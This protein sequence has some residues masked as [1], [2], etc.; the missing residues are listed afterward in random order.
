MQRIQDAFISYG[1]A[2]SRQFAKRLRDCL[3]ES[4]L[5]VWF[6]FDDIPIGVDYQNQ[7][8]DGI[9]RSN[10]F[11]FIISPHSVNSAY[12]T[13]EIELALKYHKRIIPLLHVEEISFD[14]WQ[15]RHP[16]KT[17]DDWDSEQEQSR[18]SSF[19]NLH[20]E[21]GKINWVYF[22]DGV[23]SFEVGLRGL[24]ATIERQQSY[25]YQ[26]T[27]L[28]IQALAWQRQQRQ[29]AYLLTQAPLVEANAWLQQRFQ[30]EQPPCLPTDLHCEFITESIKAADGEMTQIFL[31]YSEDDRTIQE[32]IRRRLMREGLTVWVNTQDI[33]TAEDFQSAINRGI[34]KANTLVFLL[35]P[36]SIA[37]EYCQQELSYAR[38]Y[39]K[40]IIPLLVQPLDL[41][42]LP[43]DLRT[44]QF[45]DFSAL[46]SDPHFDRAINELLR[47]LQTAAD[48]TDRHKRLLVRALAWERQGRDRKFLLRG[49]AFTEAQAWLTQPV[50]ES[51]TPTDLHMA[52]I[53]ASRDIHQFYDAFISYGR[54]DSKAFATQLYQHLSDRGFQVWFDQN[55]IPLAVDF[56]Q[57]IN[58]GIEKSHNF[59]FVI[60]PHSVNSTYCLK[61][62][63]WAVRHN[64]RIVP[65]LHVEEV[66]YETWQQ[67]HPN[68]SV[69]EWQAYQAA[70]KQHIF[71]NMPPA[72]GKINWLNAREGIDEY[73]A[74]LT[75]L[76]GLFH[77]HDNY[78][79]QHTE[80]LIKALAWARHQ[81]Q[82]N[83][84]LTG[85]ERL[86]GQ[87]WL[88]T[89]FR[90]EQPPCH[91][92]P[93]HAEL[94]TES[95]KAANGGMTQVFLSYAEENRAV[96]ETIQ[97]RLIQA[98][99]TVWADTGDIQT[100][101]DFEVALQRG[102]EEADNV[103]YLISK[104]ALNSTYC[105][106]EIKQALSLNKRVIPMLVEPM[107]LGQLSDTLRRIQFVNL[108]D[109]NT[110][111][112]LDKDLTELL[113]TLRQNAAYYSQ[114]KRLLVSAL[115]WQRQKQ[116]TSL[117]LQ[118]QS[119]EKA[120]SWAQTA[121]QHPQHPILPIQRQFL[122]VS[123]QQPPE[124]TL[125]VFICHHVNDFDFSAQLQSTLVVQG[126]STWFTPEGAE[127]DAETP[128]ATHQAIDNAE[129]F[130]FVLSPSSARS[131]ACLDQLA[132]ARARQKRIVP[133][134]YRDVLQSSMP[135]EIESLPRSDFRRHDGDFLL[136]FGE[137]F[138][139][140]ESDPAHVRSHTRLLVKAT[141]W[142]IHDRDDSYLLRG[143]D[144]SISE[145]WLQQAVGKIPQPTDLQQA[146]LRASQL[147]P[148]KKIRGRSVA[149]TAI[150]TTGIIAALRLLGGLQPLELLA[151]DQFL[152]LRPSESAQ[153]ER[154]LIVKVD[155]QSGEWLREQ[156]ITEHYE[157][158]I[159]TIP[160][161]A[162]DQAIQYLIEQDPQLIGLD[163]YRDFPA[164][165]GL[166]QTLAQTDRLLGIC[167]SASELESDI[168]N[169][170][171]PPFRVGF[172]NLLVDGS[173]TVRRHYLN[174]WIDDETDCA[175]QES[176]SLL[177]AKTYL[178]HQD[179]DYQDPYAEEI[180][181]P[182]QLGAVTVPEITGNGT[183]YGGNTRLWGWS[184][185]QGY[186]T[187]LNYRIVDGQLENF[188]DAVSLSEVVQGT[189]SPDLIRDRVVLI[190]YT[191]F[192]DRN[193]DD[194]NTPY[195]D[196]VPGV[197]L[198]GQMTSQLISAVVE[199]RPLIRWW[200]LWIETG[201]L[202]CWA[203]IGGL[204]F[205]QFVR[206]RPLA[207]ASV[208][209]VAG[210]TLGCYGLLIG[211]VL[212]VPWV[213]ALLSWGVTGGSIGYLT[214]RHRKS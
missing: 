132:Y 70:G 26:H 100:G 8:D 170:G 21:I 182:L 101:E 99:L 193:S 115:K 28:L 176:F 68:G 194:F 211:P 150:V 43:A 156:M 32:R 168:P 31:S 107:D 74:A 149:V 22:R 112:D 165:P 34:E 208:A 159:G 10:N 124:Q 66:S 145:Q 191:D 125:G 72:I 128:E 131:Q 62:I 140:L 192:S 135:P 186:Q 6:D 214:Y 102:I 174:Q 187:M 1:R 203:G 173:T 117:L 80:L 185:L 52:Y 213:P 178:D 177:L 41:D 97:A 197:Y 172:S 60:S 51:L 199:D 160:E 11:L 116:N 58:D 169:Q 5:E 139:T 163:F 94:I 162:L 103:V 196:S 91:P 127:G 35:S 202:L 37:S 7:I 210:L 65:V 142:D 4:G 93:L 64:K 24:L 79:H 137:L 59:L 57:Q 154:I 201:W 39:H 16:D 73:D 180:T 206:L 183:A 83:Y 19:P 96:K 23:D 50:P 27:Q 195:R 155:S 164:E 56:Q 12:C 95:I 46:A 47:A 90:D 38:K 151:Y 147:L 98:G 13:K 17:A 198:H 181:V 92:T 25:V 119:L 106:Y 63:D 48:Y 78:V 111:L 200:P 121:E 114:H 20:P 18:H 71:P 3:S 207:I 138:R 133:V 184:D 85:E 89:Q 167:Q 161:A 148:F 189:V 55:D 108:S 104:A 2:D 126:K 54:I 129:N 44:L 14:T 158:G 153:D 36:H 49:M 190:G 134:L 110:P 146:Y 144:L 143:Q 9:E 61:E 204:V 136:N 123:Q 152:R 53:E 175:P 40:R 179:I 105:Q 69:E 82:V 209:S 109:N 67:R 15:Q 42:T 212:W 120:L 76:I 29:S 87:R 30:G 118:R 171:L 84:L 86:S 130:L 113:R 77:H 88:T 188:A 166:S 75:E 33:R 157:P 205:W 122:S 45:V 81:R 141:E